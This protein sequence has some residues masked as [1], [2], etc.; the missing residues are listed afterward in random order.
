MASTGRL[1]RLSP[2]LGRRTIRLSCLSLFEPELLWFV[3]L[4]V[5]EEVLASLSSDAKV[6]PFIKAS[7]IRF[8]EL[9]V[10][11]VRVEKFCYRYVAPQ[12]SYKTEGE[13]MSR[14]CDNNRTM[15]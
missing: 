7:V 14:L 10:L 9:I 11:G 13:K 5:E 15:R 8:W 6:K 12:L 3:S 1:I 2:R 4:L